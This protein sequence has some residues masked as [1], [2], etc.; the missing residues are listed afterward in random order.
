MA[1][2]VIFHPL[3]FDD[4]DRLD[5]FIARDSPERATAFIGRLGFLCM[6]LAEF[7]ERG[8]R[9]E[10]L[11][12]DVRTLSFERRAVIAYRIT[13]HAVIILHVF[14]ALHGGRVAGDTCVHCCTNWFARCAPTACVQ[15]RPCAAS[16]P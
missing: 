4:L 9:R 12:D 16:S 8:R 15:V 14:C 11:G 13:G 10:E 7:P 1:Y 2:E 6:S 3:A 5:D